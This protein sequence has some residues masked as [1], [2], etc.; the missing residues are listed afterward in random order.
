MFGISYLAVSKINKDI[1]IIMDH[2]TFQGLTRIYA[3]YPNYQITQQ[4]SNVYRDF[5]E[6][7]EKNKKIKAG[8]RKLDCILKV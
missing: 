6:F 8:L 1:Q 7:A 3:N 2:L 4:V 5:V